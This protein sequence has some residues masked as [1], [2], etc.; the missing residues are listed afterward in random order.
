MTSANTSHR[1]NHKLEPSDEQTEHAAKYQT[2]LG[3]T[4]RLSQANP[5]VFKELAN[6]LLTSGS[7]TDHWK[8][9]FQEHDMAPAHI[10]SF[11][12][13]ASGMTE[14]DRN[15]V[16]QE[17]ANI[18]AKPLE[19]RIN[20]WSN[21]RLDLLDETDSL[22]HDSYK[23]MLSHE[24]N[25][26]A[27]LMEQLKGDVQETLV[28]GASDE[29]A[30]AVGH[31]AYLIHQVDNAEDLQ[32]M[33]YHHRSPHGDELQQLADH[34]TDLLDQRFQE[35]I[36]SHHPQVNETPATGDDFQETFRNFTSGYRKGDIE[37]L[38]HRYASESA[39]R[40]I[41]PADSHT[42]PEHRDAWSAHFQEIYHQLAY[43]PSPD[44][45]T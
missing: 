11:K 12:K 40:E 16:A 32:V 4:D 34:R 30:Q 28:N 38:A 20:R 39:D 44:S 3:Y 36:A 37:R 26:A 24:A 2:Y 35:H 19:A 17:T 27:L 14:D 29:L 41:R 42:L 22:D 10:Q 15:T 31:I 43:P 33:E 5:E 7:D 18:I 21:E 9:R 8:Q 13:A 25:D 1:V 23:L 6:I 45:S